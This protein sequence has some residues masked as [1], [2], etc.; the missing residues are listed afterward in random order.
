MSEARI[1]PKTALLFYLVPEKGQDS[2]NHRG[3][4]P[5]AVEQEEMNDLQLRDAGDG[6]SDNGRRQHTNPRNDHLPDVVLIA[7][8]R[9]PHDID[10]CQRRSSTKN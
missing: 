10:G 5:R 2:W 1:A 6:E 8:F 7:G 9:S 3:R 4:S